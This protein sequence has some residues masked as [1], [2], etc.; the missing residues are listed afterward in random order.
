MLDAGDWTRRERQQLWDMRRASREMAIRRSPLSVL[1]TDFAPRV[2]ALGL[3]LW[4]PMRFRNGIFAA[5][6]FD[7]V[8]E[9]DAHHAEE[10]ANHDGNLAQ[11]RR[12]ERKTRSTA[13]DLADT[14]HA[15]SLAGELLAMSAMSR[16]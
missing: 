12:H 1:F 10:R 7:I 13:I 9:H 14:M 3:A 4:G 8:P 16:S 11:H 15:Q 2:N 5:G 6:A